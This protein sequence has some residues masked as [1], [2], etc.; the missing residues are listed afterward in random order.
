MALCHVLFVIYLNDLKLR[1]ENKK[2][3][4]A[5]KKKKIKLVMKWFSFHSAK[6]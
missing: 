4:K 3:A 2:Y 6:F 5:K 1:D